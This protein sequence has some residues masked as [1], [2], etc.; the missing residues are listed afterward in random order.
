MK[1]HFSAALCACALAAL[2][3]TSPAFADAGI[4]WDLS[5]RSVLTDY[6]VPQSEF[7]HTWLKRHPHRLIEDKVKD[8]SGERITASVLIE[9]QDMHVG[10][11]LAWWFVQTKTSASIC[12]YHSKFPDGRCLDLPQGAVLRLAKDIRAFPAL[13]YADVK[14]PSFALGEDEKGNP[15]LGN[16]AGVVSLYLAGKTIQRPVFLF[17]LSE[18]EMLRETDKTRARRHDLL[19]ANQGRLMRAAKRASA[20]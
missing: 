3:S 5:Y 18:D 19:K 9:M 17:E 16:Y 15:V 1:R 4:P 13:A 12:E 10:E 11:P 8:Y 6:A 2:T 14:S 20:S 7:I